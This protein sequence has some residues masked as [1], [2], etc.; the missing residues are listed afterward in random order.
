MQVQNPITL[1]PDRL[2]G[3]NSQAYS[4]KIRKTFA[5]VKINIPLLDVIQQMPPYT[6]FLKELCTTKRATV[7]PKR[8][9]PS[10]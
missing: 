6:K 5:Q 8:A 10:L 4:D 2:K 1:F 9:F 3:K 7:V